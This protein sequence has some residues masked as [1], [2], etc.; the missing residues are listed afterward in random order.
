MRLSYSRFQRC[1]LLLISLLVLGLGRPSDAAAQRRR[2]PLLP[3]RAYAREDT[4]Y[5]VRRLFKNQDAQS[6]QRL[7]L[8]AG[9]LSGVAVGAFLP[10]PFGNPGLK[11]SAIATGAVVAGTMSGLALG[12]MLRF[13]PAR[14]DQV[15]AAYE[16]GEPLPRY[17]RRRLR[18]EHFLPG[19]SRATGF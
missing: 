13:R 3:A 5:A 8:W 10:A 14:R 11:T 16:Q 6:T 1:S 4:V 18:P 19:S 12:R 9:G 17:V 7:A 2:G 15:L